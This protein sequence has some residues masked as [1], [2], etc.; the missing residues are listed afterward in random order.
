MQAS[1]NQQESLAA[2]EQLVLVRALNLGRLL[3]LPG[4]G[5][6][7]PPSELTRRLA[8]RRARPNEL[9]KAQQQE[10]WQISHVEIH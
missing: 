10:I 1:Q 9:L 2:S 8:G 7:A 4:S 5:A 6:T 3:Q